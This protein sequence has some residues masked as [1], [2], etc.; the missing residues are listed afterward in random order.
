[1]DNMFTDIALWL[2]AINFVVGIVGLSFFLGWWLKVGQATSI[3]AIMT[4]WLFGHAIS[5]STN[6]YGRWLGYHI[7]ITE[8]SWRYY[9]SKQWW[10][11]WR[12]IIE[13]L[14]GIILVWTVVSRTFKKKVRSPSCPCSGCSFR[15][16][17][18]KYQVLIN[19]K[20]K[21]KK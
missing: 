2:Y 10:W 20:E 7:P 3:Y 18:E 5:A 6:F 19:C 16:Q 8:E 17:C 4:L 14:A 11:H 1:M 21:G 15:E 12:Y 9:I 13:S